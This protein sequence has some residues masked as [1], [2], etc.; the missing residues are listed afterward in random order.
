M[1]KL[2][3]MFIK[4]TYLNIVKSIYDKPTANIILSG[5]NVKAFL[6]GSERRQACSLLPLLLHRDFMGGLGHSK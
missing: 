4:R 6:L 3:L 1:I 5:E 2:S